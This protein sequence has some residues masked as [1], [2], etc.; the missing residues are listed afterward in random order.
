VAFILL[1]LVGAGLSIARSR[2]GDVQSRLSVAE[3]RE[4]KQA[5]EAGTVRAL[6]LVNTN[7]DYQ[8]NLRQGITVCEQTL[9]LFGLLEGGSESWHRLDPD[10]Q[11]QLG[12]DARELM[13]LLAGARVQL[14]PGNDRLV[15]DALALLERAEALPGLRPSKALYQDR[16]RYLELIGE[17]DKALV[18]QELADETPAESARDYYLLA[19]SHARKGGEKEYTR[20]ITALDRAIALN[21]RHYW[22]W[23]QRGLCR[24]EQKDH[25]QAAFD[26][27]AAVG[28]WPELAWGHFNYA[29]A[30]CQAGRP[31]DAIHSYSQ[32]LQRDPELIPAYVN[33]GLTYLELRRFAE[34]LADFEQAINLGKADAILYTGQGI[35]L[36]GLGKSI[37]ADRAFTRA[38]ADD[39]LTPREWVRVRWSYGFAVS[40]RLPAQ[41]RRA[42]TEVIRR[43]PTNPQAL[44]GLAMLAMAQGNTQEA[45]VYFDRAIKSNPT[46]L[47][48]RRYRAIVLARLAKFE[49]AQ[50]DV[51][52]CLERDPRGGP[53]LYAAACVAALAADKLKNAQLAEQAIHLLEGAAQRGHS[54]EKAG[55][56]PDLAALRK[57][58]RF[59]RL[60]GVSRETTRAEVDERRR[61]ARMKWSA[62]Q[63]Y[64]VCARELRVA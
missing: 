61:P 34:A 36:E 62:E 54:L 21:P 45:R 29:Y 23:V 25:V 51:N 27:G 60:T 46:F 28:L 43:E 32:A 10:E 4:R 20:A 42:F 35:A 1:G 40:A 18:L 30:L 8:D 15:R 37:E 39:S 53:T 52:W 14:A 17:R 12:E 47:E 13:L 22:S 49:L 57:Y 31:L 2:L 26:L 7:L 56:D 16:A 55:S 9:G 64:T 19:A 38:F 24:L 41:A 48:A 44:Y 3:V 33:R 50:T 63:G 5:F 11:R 59:Q 58:S 6:C